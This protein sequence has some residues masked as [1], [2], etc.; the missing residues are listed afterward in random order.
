MS[1]ATT[2]LGVRRPT[3]APVFDFDRLLLGSSSGGG[4]VGDDVVADALLGFAYDPPAHGAAALDDV[5]APLPGADKRPRERG[6]VADGRSFRRAGAALPA[7]PTE[8][9]T[10]FVPTPPPLPP[11]Q[12]QQQQQRWELPDA[13]FVRGAG[14]AEAKKGGA[15]A[16][17]DDHDD[18][19]HHHHHNQAVQSAAA[20]ER[21]RRIS[22]KT[23]ELS[24]LIPGAARMNST[25][26]MLQAAA[27]HVRLLQAQVGMLALIHSSGEAKAASSMAASREHHQMMMMRALLASGGVQERLAGEGRCLVPTSLVRAIADD[28]AM[29]TSNPALSRDVNR[30]KDSLDQQQQQ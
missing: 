10:R 6:V 8:L 14:A 26:E 15:A 19:R 2:R 30:F 24:R 28:D 13:V 16:S 12:Q 29:A 18:G 4:M 23:A 1:T 21:R 7:P 3:P 20:R 17:H 22:S 9:V 25:A 5:L 11:V 27:R